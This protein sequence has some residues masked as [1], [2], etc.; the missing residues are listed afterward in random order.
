MTQPMLNVVSEDAAIP[1]SEPAGAETP[2]TDAL[3]DLSS[4][5]P[6]QVQAPSDAASLRPFDWV[7]Y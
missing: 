5:E 4:L 3:E 1:T 2:P 6:A 7:R